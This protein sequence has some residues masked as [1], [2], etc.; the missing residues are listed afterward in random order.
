MRRNKTLRVFVT[1]ALALIL[2]LGTM[3]TVFAAAGPITGSEAS[4]AQ[5]VIAK[6]LKMPE[7]TPTP[8]ASFT[9]TFTAKSV[10][11]SE[12]SADV[13]T[14]PPITDKTASFAAGA[15]STTP[16]GGITT[17]TAE[18]ASL[19]AGITWPHAG[20]Y[21]YTVTE[22][23]GTY[24]SI[25]TTKETMTYSQAVYEISVYVASNAAG[26]DYYVSAIATTIVK[27][28]DGTTGTGK[29]DPGTASSTITGAYQAMVFTN[30]YTKTNGTIDDPAT[31]GDDPTDPGAIDNKVLAVS[32]TVGG[33]Y[34]DL[35]KYFTFSLTLTRAAVFATP[36]TYR[37]YVVDAS[38]TVVTA[39]ANYAGTIVTD[40]NGN[41]Y[42]N[43]TTGAAATINLKHGQKLVLADAPIGTS[44]LVTE[45]GVTGYTT[46]ITHTV[47][48]TE[49]TLT[50]GVLT[51]GTNLIGNGVN[52]AVYT[53]TNTTVA[54]TGI[55]LEHLPFILMLA[56]AAGA[57]VVFVVVKSRKKG[58]D[59]KH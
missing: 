34:G 25:D 29:T 28:D 40:V 1:L 2:C 35:G 56:L 39:T 12:L 42:I 27:T 45:T 37:V 46:V 26:T 4:P 17:V 19:F 24:T 8:A 47:N 52:S 58:Y 55:T 41:G 53:N 54:P 38:D 14:M 5:A 21:V 48:G 49:S 33:T 31:P 36:Q 7:G 50:S 30:V 44:Y 6:T 13:S 10:D 23:N 3:T 16:S 57:L 43:V 20:V 59:A 18:T 11:G 9:F 22:T 32:K 51:T 15:T